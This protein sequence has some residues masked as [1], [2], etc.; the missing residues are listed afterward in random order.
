MPEADDVMIHFPDSYLPEEL[1]AERI[2]KH[3][4]PIEG[5]HL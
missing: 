3:A 4:A 2:E 5:R 1:S